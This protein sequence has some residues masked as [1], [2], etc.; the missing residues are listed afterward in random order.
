METGMT[1]GTYSHQQHGK[2]IPGGPG[3]GCSGRMGYRGR[4]LLGMGVLNALSCILTQDSGEHTPW[5]PGEAPR[6]TQDSGNS[7]SP[8]HGVRWLHAL[9]VPPQSEVTLYMV[10]LTEQLHFQFTP[11]EIHVFHFAVG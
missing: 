3:F 4:G 10:P 5:P 11:T 9:C 2:A 8:A 7:Q 6:H 1:H